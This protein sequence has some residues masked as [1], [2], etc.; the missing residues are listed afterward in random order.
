MKSDKDNSCAVLYSGGTDSTCSAALMAEKFA[1]VHLLTFYQ[2][3]K[4]Q[5]GQIEKTI[6]KLQKKF[7]KT[8][9]VHRVIETTRLVEHLSYDRY[10]AYFF[11]HGWLVLSTP[12]FTTLSWHMS[13]IIYCR[14]NGVAVVADGLTRELM[15][16]PGHMDAVIKIF[17]KMYEG[18]GIS[19]IN[20]VRSWKTPPD[21]QFIDR[22]IVD[23]HGFYLPGG[24][25]KT[26]LAGTTGQYLYKL[27][28]MPNPNVKGSSLDHRMQFDCY[29]FVLYNMV[30]F[31]LYLNFASYENLCLKMAELFLEKT[32]DAKILLEGYFQKGKTSR[33]AS[34]LD[35]AFL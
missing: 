2:N 24:P 9:F 35:K 16:F 31:W 23:Q 28:V 1:V 11:R 26:G 6:A 32:R 4:P 15:H 33:L 8:R 21:Q 30:V 29:P 7:P 3:K 17:K 12:G 34:L 14:K 10:L 22:L 13:A 19:Y 18:F 25:A 5:T 20:P 27:G